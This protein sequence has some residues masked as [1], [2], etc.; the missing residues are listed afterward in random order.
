MLHLRHLLTRDEA[1]RLRQRFHPWREV[2]IRKVNS[3]AQQYE[4]LYV[5]EVEQILERVATRAAH[6][7]LHG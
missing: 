6:L 3:Q 7:S 5:L 2:D 4:K 1:L